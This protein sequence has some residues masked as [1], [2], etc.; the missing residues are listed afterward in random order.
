MI[1]YLKLKRDK[2]LPV[3][4]KDSKKLSPKARQKYFVYL[5]SLKLSYVVTNVS[6]EVIDEKGISFS[7]KK[8]IN[9]CLKK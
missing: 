7:V 8:A 3:A 6:N 2:S 1:K 5:N 9:E 4:G